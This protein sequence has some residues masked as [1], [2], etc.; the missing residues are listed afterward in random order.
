ME[1][2]Q[3]R[4]L[5]IIGLLINSLTLIISHFTKMPD[6]MPGSL[7]GIGIGIIILSFK[8]KRQKPSC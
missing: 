1:R 2:Q 8:Y 5:L 4:M 6:L 3:K 7:M